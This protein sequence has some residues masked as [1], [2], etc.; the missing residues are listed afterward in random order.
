MAR[1][2][3]RI[4]LEGNLDER[5][6]SF[7]KALRKVS[8]AAG[9][10]TE[11]VTGASEAYDD[12][13]SSADAAD[14]ATAGAFTQAVANTTTLSGAFSAVAPRVDALGA[15]FQGAGA[16]MGEIAAIPIRSLVR[17]DDAI[18]RTT[19]RVEARF[20]KIVAPVRRAWSRVSDTVQRATDKVNSRVKDMTDR[21]R[22]RFDA[23]KRTLNTFARSAQ[24]TLGR[25][26]QAFADAR[27]RVD[28]FGRQVQASTLKTQR[29]LR[30]VGQSF[31]DATKR[32]SVF[33]RRALGPLGKS[34]DSARK[35]VSSFA[36]GFR[37]HTAK[38]TKFVRTLRKMRKGADG[39]GKSL[40]KFGAKASATMSVFKGVILAQ[41]VTKIFEIGAAAL[42]AA[43]QLGQFGQRAEFA[44]GVV[45][46]DV[47][48]GG[49]NAGAKVFE[50]ASLRAQT[51]GIDLEETAER[52]TNFLSAGID[53]G[54]ADDLVQLSADFNR[55]GN[56][57]AGSRISDTIQEIQAKAGQFTGTEMMSLIDQLKDVD[58]SRQAIEDQ[59]SR[60]AGEQI[61]LETAI[62]A[63]D[64]DASALTQAIV[65]ASNDALGQADVGETAERFAKTGVGA[66]DRAVTSGKVALAKAGG[67]L[68]DSL[69]TKLLPIV[70]RLQAWLASDQGAEFFDR[71]SKT[72]STVVDIGGELVEVFTGSFSETFDAVS[73]GFGAV[74]GADQQASIK[75]FIPVLK[76]LASV[77]GTVTAVVVTLGI[78]FGAVV[79]GV[80]IAATALADAIINAVQSFGAW[81]GKAVFAVTDWFA[82]LS[83]KFDA[84]GETLFEKL[85]SIGGFVV[86][87]LVEGI[88]A[89][90]ILPVKAVMG[91]GESIVGGFKG[92]LGIES[93]SKVMFGLG[94]NTGEGVTLGLK[95]QTN[96]TAKAGSNMGA[97]VST[98]FG[99]GLDT[100]TSEP[101][102]K[103]PD[104]GILTPSVTTDV[105]MPA[106]LGSRDRSSDAFDAPTTHATPNGFAAP[107]AAPTGGG[108]RSIDFTLQQEIHGADGTTAEEIARISAR[109]ARREIEA[110]FEQIDL[111]V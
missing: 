78:V 2:E 30:R 87:G 20:G 99:Q 50:L 101:L 89:A 65:A 37:R 34:F 58:I 49:A 10:N 52:Y 33:A 8:R 85:K 82:D 92:V 14:T 88:K 83:A 11:K 91:I 55:A 16:T 44:M 103:M 67:A 100:M 3:Y 105:R 106:V 75:D 22:T 109:E 13:A 4:D 64:I 35:R 102:F 17:L 51:L 95:S 68:V 7:A 79:A 27:K 21:V 39:S 57:I 43:V 110:L 56:E 108:G 96:A 23:G 69:G 80:A 72:I 71:L 45:G 98:G 19:D 12:V 76:T 5:A 77:I 26:S 29:T 60:A 61:E 62:K 53:I 46:R 40:S 42:R 47:K 1:T 94:V 84:G 41:A 63:G 28:R 32:V 6:S 97:S 38:L 31:T 66:F 48:G 81:L 104:L 74:F 73:E 90:A 59:L 86:D 36:K 24:R 9:D 111:E 93:P 18:A 25:A 70:D 15:K 54:V 107:V